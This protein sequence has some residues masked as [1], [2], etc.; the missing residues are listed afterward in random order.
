[1]I[2]AGL[3]TG[4]VFCLLLLSGCNTLRQA[5]FP[6]SLEP[7]AKQATGQSPQ[8]REQFISALSRQVQ[9][10]KQQGQLYQALQLS[11]QGRELLPDD[12]SL[13]ALQ[14]HLENQLQTEQRHLGWQREISRARAD[15]AT[16]AVLQEE[17]RLEPASSYR[18]W[19]LQR[20]GN[21]LNQQAETLRLCTRQAIAE[22][23]WDYA[24][25][26]IN[27]AAEI[28]G[29]DFV[30]VESRQFRT[31]T[32]APKKV[33]VITPPQK[34]KPDPNYTPQIQAF[35]RAMKNGRLVTAANIISRLNAAKKPPAIL[36]KL[37][38]RLALAIEREIAR[39]EAAAA[40]HYRQQEYDQARVSWQKILEL[41]PGHPEAGE[42]LKRVEK[43][44]QS[45]QELQEPNPRP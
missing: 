38:S 10:R 11:R 25:S 27:L 36:P 9:A 15:L 32:Q 6:P 23:L 22:K 29:K 45:L 5:Q 41:Q 43:V 2:R 19:R 1:M 37:K 4:L 42:R 13:F 14:T 33:V 16:R 20:L 3:G 30:A 17:Q 40:E 12:A 34:P 35:E 31:A 18:N 7:L 24:E 21:E 39:L 26:C 28:R 8:A 44:L